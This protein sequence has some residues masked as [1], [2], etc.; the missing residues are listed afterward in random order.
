M[1]MMQ[2][3]RRPRRRWKGRPSPIRRAN[4]R[5]PAPRP[6]ALAGTQR[7]GRGRWQARLRNASNRPAKVRKKNEMW[8]GVVR[9]DAVWCGATRCVINHRLRF[10][11]PTSLL[12]CVNHRSHARH[13]Q[14]YALYRRY[15]QH[16]HI[17]IR[18][19]IHRYGIKNQRKTLNAPYRLRRELDDAG[20]KWRVAGKGVVEIRG[21]LQVELLGRHGKLQQATDLARRRGGREG[22]RQGG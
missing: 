10:I 13:T 1:M 6:G 14:A 3:R 20:G 16:T 8:R 9:C 5:V 17:Y 11:N 12:T 4:A 18:K 22:R 19:N 2:T 7:C 21:V 15:T